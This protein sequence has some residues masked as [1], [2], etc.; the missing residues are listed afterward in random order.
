[1]APRRIFPAKSHWQRPVLYRTHQTQMLKRLKAEMLKYKPAIHCYFPLSA[2]FNNRKTTNAKTL[3][4][5]FSNFE[6][7]KC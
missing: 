2:R 5:R 3:T 7:L 1:M 4:N 6:T